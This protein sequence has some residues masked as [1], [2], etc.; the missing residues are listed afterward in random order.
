MPHLLALSGSLRATSSNR[1]LLEAAAQLVP[2][3]VTVG[4]FEGVADLPAFNPDLDAAPAPAAVVAWRRALQTADALLLSSPEYAH[5]VPGA[6]KNALDWVVG[7]GELVDKPVALLN[8]SPR[9]AFAHPQLAEILT[10]MSAR[11]VPDA[12]IA[13]ALS[14]RKL[15][16]AEIAALPEFAEPL[17]AA[18][19]A[20][21]AQL[22]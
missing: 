20:L 5:G 19:A 2:A 6:L 21:L 3:G 16:A 18:L 10:T 13:L 11:V 8:P 15:A 14:H 17:R 22:G 1:S 4:F 9:S 12:S 7:S